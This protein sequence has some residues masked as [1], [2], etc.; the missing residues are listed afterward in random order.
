[1]FEPAPYRFFGTVSSVKGALFRL[2]GM[3]KIRVKKNL[4]KVTAALK[5]FVAAIEM[6]ED[7][8]DVRASSKQHIL[9][10]HNRCQPEGS[11]VLRFGPTR[12]LVLCYLVDHS[13]PSKPC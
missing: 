8:N 4:R 3:S 12:S 2:V 5:A 10:F 13:T 6:D 9:D 7:Q 1:M 11:C